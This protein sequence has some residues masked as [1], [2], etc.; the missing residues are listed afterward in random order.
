M[1]LLICMLVLLPL[2]GC[3]ALHTSVA[4]GKLDVQTR[5]SE[6]IY[7]DPVE[8]EL[9]TIF[10][11]IRQT[12]AEYQLPLADDVRA[13]LLSRGYQLVDSPQQAQYWL[14]VNVRTVLKERPEVV[15]ASGEYNMSPE[16]IHQLLYPGIAL[17]EPEPERM[18]SQR[19][20]SNVA[21]YADATYGTNID[22]KDI[23][24][25]LVVL[26]AW[27]GAEYVGNQLVQ[28]KYYTMLTDIQLAERIAPDSI[29]MVQESSRQQLKQ[30]DSGNIELLWELATDRRKYQV[31]VVSFANKANL[32]WSD[33]EQPL[34]Q[35]L[36]RSL[37]GIF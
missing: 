17:P 1:R 12:A 8:P 3:M 19:R 16:Q 14:Q 9:R 30:G 33:A 18:A 25:A 29:G 36:L 26:A 13:L 27:A 32:S 5:M 11:D 28:D 35:G 31:K 4:K 37:A 20:A 24:R 23:A 7:L 6:T 34:H 2:S 22:G 21:V 15:L 10:I